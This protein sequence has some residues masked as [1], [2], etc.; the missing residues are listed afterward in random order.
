MPRGRPRKELDRSTPAGLL[1]AKV[2]DLRDAKGWDSEELARRVFSSKTVIDKVETAKATPS[3]DLVRKLDSVLDA[4]GALLEL[5]PLLPFQSFEDYAEEFLANQKRA[6]KLY[7]Y[8]QVVPGL[9]QTRAYARAMAQSGEM[10]TGDDPESV[11]D[12]RM[13]RQAILDAPGAPWLLAVLDE[14]AIRRVVGSKAV[15][16]EQ[17]EHLLKL[18]DRPRVEVRVLPFGE[19]VPFV[20][21]GSLSILT[22][23][24][25]VT[26]A[27]T[28]GISTGRMLQGDEATA[29]SVLYDRVLSSALSPTR[30]TDL[31]RTAIEEYGK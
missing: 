20:L 7:E 8:S 5:W 30:S 13:E 9:M 4:N 19:T 14:A 11:A 25:G 24:S 3:E 28:E 10:V 12:L 6:V 29:Y 2:R 16:V 1:G 22:M 15:M 27:Y 26:Y 31:I 17:L 18:S 21:V 23:R